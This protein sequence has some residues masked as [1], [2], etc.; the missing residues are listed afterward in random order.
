MIDA[1]FEHIR[2]IGPGRLGLAFGW[3]L[4]QRRA[5]GSLTFI[6]RRASA[7]SHPVFAAGA[8]YSTIHDARDLPPASL[9]VITVQD[10]AIRSVAE[11]QASLDSP[12]VPVLHTS[13]VHGSEVLE[14]V[15][16]L[17]WPV[18]SLHPLV[19]IPDP[20]SSAH[21]LEGAWF[22]VEG[23][24]AAL[25]AARRLVSIL[26][27]SCLEVETARKA[28]YHAAAVFASNFVVT[29]MHTAEKL[30]VEAGAP[31]ED[32]IAALS[33]LATGALADVESL[34]P[35]A[36]LTGPIARGDADTIR[37]HL[38]ALSEEDRPLYSELAR[39]TIQIAMHAGLPAMAAVR[40]QDILQVEIG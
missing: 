24:P 39:S 21:K 16:A 10:G 33:R 8:D 29:L 31:P 20:V 2:I 22:G 34:G 11:W 27:G 5:S 30:L 26:G 25:N 6:G 38:R 7:P 32:A 4:Q 3:L 18:G 17:G 12:R 13:G 35:V 28:T 9:V 19:A 1:R 15:A 36:A 14:S 23:T 37:L 40:L